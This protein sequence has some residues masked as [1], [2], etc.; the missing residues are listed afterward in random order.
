MLA[1][2]YEGK[3]AP[4]LKDAPAPLP[5]PENAILKGDVAKAIIRPQ[6]A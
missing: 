3:G 1:Y 5:H 6:S 4:A 2:V